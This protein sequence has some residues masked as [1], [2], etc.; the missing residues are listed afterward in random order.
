MVETVKRLF[1]RPV[2]EQNSEEVL[3]K[4]SDIVFDT[5]TDVAV[6]LLMTTN[7]IIPFT[8]AILL[9][10]ILRVN[11]SGVTISSMS[12][13]R[14]ID[15]E[16]LPGNAMTY[17]EHFHGQKVKDDRVRARGKI[18]DAVFDFEASELTDF[19]LSDSRLQAVFGKVSR[20]PARRVRTKDGEILI[21]KGGSSNE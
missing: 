6:A 8:R 15:P 2:F 1:G 13:I 20:I 19:I 14:T 7:S 16:E 12:K 4:I 3:G 10:D 18:R 11:K 21:T 9:K 17:F 5:E